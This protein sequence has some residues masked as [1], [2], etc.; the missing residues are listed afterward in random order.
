MDKA[1]LDY[2]ADHL[3]ASW[4]NGIMKFFT[5]F[6]ELGIFG[7][8]CGILCL[9][10]KKY[11]KVGF[12][13]LICMAIGFL[14]GNLFLKNIIAR[15]RPCVTFDY[16]TYYIKCPNEYSMPSGHT[17]HSFIPVFLF[18]Y[19]KKW[20]IGIPTLII[21][22]LIAFSRMYFAVHYPS[23]ILVGI[24]LAFFL[25]TIVWLILTKVPKLKQIF[26]YK[27]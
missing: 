13:I 21:A 20:K 7:L 1:I 8:T 2:I 14:V 17:L 16:L 10:F 9:I 5:L 25:S 12:S 26:L 3:H 6:G 11:R 4:L 27:E 18:F 22:S 24:L 19:F 23:D 15:E